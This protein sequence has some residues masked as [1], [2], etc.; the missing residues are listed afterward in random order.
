LLFIDFVTG[1]LVHLAV[2]AEVV[3]EGAEL[4]A[5]KARSGSCVFITTKCGAAL[6]RCRSNGL[7]LNW[8]RSSHPRSVM[9]KVKDRKVF[10][11]TLMA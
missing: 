1:D 6:A 8:L 4:A 10:E 2:R 9:P 5:F 11:N 3:W 7:K